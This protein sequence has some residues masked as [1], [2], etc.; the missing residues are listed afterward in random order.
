MKYKLRQ[1]LARL[2]LYWFPDFTSIQLLI[3]YTYIII[4]YKMAELRRWH[5]PCFVSTPASSRGAG[6]PARRGRHDTDK[7][8]A[9]PLRPPH[10]TSHPLAIHNFVPLHSLDAWPLV[11]NPTYLPYYNTAHI[12]RHTQ[13]DR[14]IQLTFDSYVT[15]SFSDVL[16]CIFTIF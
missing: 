4:G 8:S 9:R 6:A 11:V 15:S 2:Y 12:P 13:S 1:L 14:R 5:H 16:L 10:P 7:R 3:L